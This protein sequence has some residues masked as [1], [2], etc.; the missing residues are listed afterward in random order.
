MSSPTRRRQSFRNGRFGVVKGDPGQPY[1]RYG[2]PGGY[3]EAPDWN[4]S[5]KH[6]Q[7]ASF[8]SSASW[9]LLDFTETAVGAGSGAVR[10]AGGL[11]LTGGNAGAT[12][13]DELQLIRS[14]A[15]AAGKLQ[16]CAT[17][18]AFSTV[19]TG[20]YA[21]GFGIT[22]TSFNAS[23][24]SDHASFRVATAGVMT[25]ATKDN[26]TGSATATLATL[27][28]ATDYDMALVIDGTAGVEYFYRT[29]GTT[30]VWSSGYKTTNLPRSGQLMRL[31]LA[32]GGV[33]GAWTA[34]HAYLAS[35]QEL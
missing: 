13:N 35:S 25:V 9:N 12:D 19:T 29:P 27:T 1:I 15:I 30:L 4:F 24:P 2:V 32:W 31:S 28:T 23:V 18:V 34:T 21:F 5:G 26:S 33:Q 20:T 3:Q 7:F 6:V 10:A 14:V 8:D 17:R 11:A 22:D 16:W